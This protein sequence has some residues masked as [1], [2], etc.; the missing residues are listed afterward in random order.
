MKKL[1]LGMLMLVS[2]VG[3]SQNDST[4]IKTNDDD[5]TGDTSY[6]VNRSFIV[7]NDKQNLGAVLR[8]STSGKT[9]KVNFLIV[10]VVGLGCVEN[11]T[12]LI[13]FK[14]GTLWKGNSWNKFS[15][16]G[17]AYYNITGDLAE[18]LKTKELQTIR[19]T[20]GRNYKNFTYDVKPK[21]RRYF[22]PILR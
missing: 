4:F 12:L 20:N 3:Y 7:A 5:M 13:K 2:I 10:T 1:L 17:A 15:C 14:D 18:N 8:A 9:K 6:T 11:V 22:I 16:K 19:I 21:D